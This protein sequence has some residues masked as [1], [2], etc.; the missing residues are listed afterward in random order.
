MSAK[1]NWCDQFDF[2]GCNKKPPCPDVVDLIK[3]L[4]V[5]FKSSRANNAFDGNLEA[6]FQEN[7][8]LEEGQNVWME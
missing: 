3:C 7:S 8:E 4:G 1:C 5:I 6:T 2:A